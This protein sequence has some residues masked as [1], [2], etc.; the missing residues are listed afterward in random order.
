LYAF[1]TGFNY[2]PSEV[3]QYLNGWFSEIG[4]FIGIFVNGIDVSSYLTLSQ[5]FLSSNLMSSYDIELNLSELANAGI[6]KN[7]NNNIAFVLDTIL[8]EYSGGTYYDGNDGLV[9]FT[10]GLQK[11]TDSIFVVIPPPPPPGGGDTPEPATLLIFGI[12][13]AGLGI[14]RKLMSK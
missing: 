7:G 9:A 2:N 4:D 1:V 3:Y 12:G 11:N 6:L 10:A 8:P 14:R 5:D 13:L